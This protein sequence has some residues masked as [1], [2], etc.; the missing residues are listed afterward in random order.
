M[1][2]PVGQEIAFPEPENEKRIMAVMRIS[3]ANTHYGKTENE[4]L[5]CL[6][7]WMSRKI[8]KKRQEESA[9]NLSGDAAPDLDDSGESVLCEN[10][11]DS[12]VAHSAPIIRAYLSHGRNCK[13]SRNCIYDCQGV[14]K[15]GEEISTK[16]E[17]GT[18]CPYAWNIPFF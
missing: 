8:L 17:T 4:H 7:A 15:E 9:Q 14:L 11:A 12:R 10:E 2:Y 16:D 3:R 1:C 6:V 18:L 13:Y 5:N